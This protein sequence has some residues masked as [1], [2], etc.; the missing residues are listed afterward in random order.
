MG[1]NFAIR[2]VVFY[3]FVRFAYVHEV[4]TAKTGI[5]TYLVLL[6]SLVT[7]P[8][9]IFNGG[10]R[11]TFSGFTGRVWL[12]FGVWLFCDSV[13]SMWFAGSVKLVWSYFQTV[14][15][16]VIIAGGV[17]LRLTEIRSMMYAFGAASLCNVLTARFF[18]DA[19]SERAEGMSI[20]TGTIG[21]A[22]DF[23]AHL[24]FVLPFII[25]AI[26]VVRSRLIKTGGCVLFAYAF[27]LCV[28]TGSRGAL[29]AI[30]AMTIFVL[31]RGPARGR[32]AILL[33]GPIVAATLLAVLPGALLQRYRTIFD[34][35]SAGLPE[36]AVASA[37]A[38]KELFRKS[39]QITAEHAL[40]GVGVGQF[41]LANGADLVKNGIHA[42]WQV[43]HNTYTQL[44]SETGL[45]GLL[46]YLSAIAGAFVLLQSVPRLTRGL[47]DESLAATAAFCLSMSLVGWTVASF[48]LSQAYTIYMPTMLGLAISMSRVANR[49]PVAVALPQAPPPRWQRVNAVPARP[50]YRGGPA[51]GYKGPG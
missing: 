40:T 32:I 35:N 3:L 49:R 16:M 5:N 38:R 51:R 37:A 25:F 50:N 11:R 44:S 48:F 39:L 27:Y 14:F 36:E 7:I 41:Q 45:T 47:P 33:A 13:F 9:V 34:E 22:N 30:A 23:A 4:I 31:F 12:A 18:A 8:L 15:P 17:A 29:L 6:S 26:I 2:C 21:N 19:S 10:L 43:T 1:R 20:G 46:L 24:I 42:E 28:S